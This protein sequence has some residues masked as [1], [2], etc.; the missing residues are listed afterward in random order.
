[1]LHATEM[2]FWPKGSAASAGANVDR[3]MWASAN[4]TLHEGP[5]RKVVVESTGDG[6]TGIFYEL[7]K[8]AHSSQDWAFLFFP[9]SQFA[10]YSLSVPSDWQRTTEEEDLVLEYGLSD[11]QLAWRRSKLITMGGDER[12][13]RKEY[14]LSWMDPF[15]I[16]DGM[17]FDVENLNRWAAALIAPVAVEGLAVFHPYNPDHLYFI[18]QDTSGG[19]GEDD[20]CLQVLR[21]DLVQAARWRSNVTKPHRQAELA[22]SVSIMYGRALVLCEANKH[23]KVVIERMSALGVNLWKSHGKDWWTQRGNSLN[24]KE[25][26]FDYAAPV[27][28]NNYVEF[29]DP[30]T[31]AQLMTMREHPDG[32]IAGA[33]TT[34]K[35]D[36]A[37]AFVLA[38]WCHKTMGR[39][40]REHRLS[41]ETRRRLAHEALGLRGLRRAA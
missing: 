8:T 18:G 27:V 10:A 39:V 19:V 6:P 40:R 31:V 13:F 29:A 3:T 24:S 15:L 30:L 21:D 37:M 22:A 4:A 23:G 5:H 7:C 41:L 36:V 35:D 16:T 12:R 1:M 2:G 26:L 20:A 9:W 33:S 34:D 28:D 25:W 38:L 17:W 11:G 32:N 14:P